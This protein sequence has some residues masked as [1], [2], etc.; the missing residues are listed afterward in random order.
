MSLIISSDKHTL[1]VKVPA[2]VTQEQL[3]DSL[4]AVLCFA[5][6]MGSEYQTRYLINTVKKKGVRTGRYFV[7]LSNPKVY[8]MLLG[9]N[10]DG[11]S[12]TE[13]YEDPDWVAPEELDPFVSS[14]SNKSW[15]DMMEEEDLQK[16]P[17]IEKK[18]P[19]L[20]QIPP[21]KLTPEQRAQDEN[22]AVQI[23]AYVEAALAHD[24]DPE[25]SHNVLRSSALLPFM[26]EKFIKKEFQCFSTSENSFP[27][28]TGKGK[29]DIVQESFPY[30]RI[31]NHGTARG[32]ERVAYVTFDSAT[33][34]ASF[35]FHMM[36]HREYVNNKTNNVFV[37]N[38]TYARSRNT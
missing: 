29:G 36:R 30:I 25:L 20:I 35:A 16:A 24:I 34:D 6:K 17:I 13:R 12:R 8:H 2:Y 28:R 32:S 9:R 26:D 18:L 19:A 38:Y 21:I 4:Q 22:K 14:G 11:S 5:A 31:I 15:A 33:R 27:V 10:P 1:T 23:T 7:W 3:C 37:V